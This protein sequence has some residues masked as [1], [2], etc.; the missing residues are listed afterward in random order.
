MGLSG[1]RGFRE[2]YRGECK[3]CNEDNH[4]TVVEAEAFRQDDMSFRAICK[5]C[6]QPLAITYQ[7]E[8]F[9]PSREQVQF[10]SELGARWV[11]KIE[12]VSH[13]FS[14]ETFQFQTED[15]G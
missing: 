15:A 1:A 5:V 6:L 8:E 7:R 3:L 13:E 11:P 4:F 9:K 12:R 2:E 10:W 14:T